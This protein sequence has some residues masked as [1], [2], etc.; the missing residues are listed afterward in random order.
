MNGCRKDA[1]RMYCKPIAEG[2]SPQL[3]RRHLRRE[4]ITCASV[5]GL[6]L[7]KGPRPYPFNTMATHTRRGRIGRA[8]FLAKA[9]VP[10]YPTGQCQRRGGN[11][12]PRHAIVHCRAHSASR[13]QIRDGRGG[14]DYRN[15][16]TDPRWAARVTRWLIRNA[17]LQQ[18]QLGAPPPPATASAEGCE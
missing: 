17:G 18:F 8:A 13:R 15:T 16:L 1:V 5:G 11:Q 12:T 3:L 2:G 6:S 14:I 4:S 7:W 10:Q 9:K